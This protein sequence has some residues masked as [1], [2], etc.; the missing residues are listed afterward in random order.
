MM[1]DDA[2]CPGVGDELDGWRE[3][4]EDCLRRT[5]PPSGHHQQWMQPELIIVF[6]CPWYMEP[7]HD[8]G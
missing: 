5:T 8:Q 6:M 7:S 1:Q 3:G 2:R 4:C